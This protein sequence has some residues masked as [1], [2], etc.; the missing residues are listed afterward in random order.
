MDSDAR[1][2]LI[3]AV[4]QARARAAEAVSEIEGDSDAPRSVESAVREAEAALTR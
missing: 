3:E 2:R 1:R 4:E